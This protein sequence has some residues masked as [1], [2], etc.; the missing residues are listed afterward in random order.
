[1]II[2]AGANRRGELL[3]VI[4]MVRPD[5]L[6]RPTGKITPPGCMKLLW[7]ISPHTGW[8]ELTYYMILRRRPGF[9]INVLIVPS[10]LLS[11]LTPL[12]FWIPPSRPDRTTLGEQILEEKI[13][14]HCW[15]LKN[16]FIGVFNQPRANSKWWTLTWYSEKSKRISGGWSPKRIYSLACVTPEVRGCKTGP[17]KPELPAGLSTKY[18]TL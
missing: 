1:M 3:I 18:V 5:D 10:L 8:Y 2:A 6:T 17:V 16:M 11:I 9:Y 14:F 15:S 12:I 4:Q 7:C 13:C